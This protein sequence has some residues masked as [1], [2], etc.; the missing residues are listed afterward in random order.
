MKQSSHGAGVG[1]TSDPVGRP[2]SVAFVHGCRRELEPVGFAEPWVPTDLSREI[3]PRRLQRQ[4]HDDTVV[5]HGD[6]L[7]HGPP[8]LPRQ[9]DRGGTG[10]RRRQH[11]G[12]PRSIE[13]QPVD[14]V[15]L[16]GAVAVAVVDRELVLDATEGESAI[17]D[18][19]GPRRHRVRTPQHRI[20]RF[21]SWGIDQERLVADLDLADA[22]ASRRVDV[23][24]TSSARRVR[25]GSSWVTERYCTDASARATCDPRRGDESRVSRRRLGGRRFDRTRAVRARRGHAHRH[26]GAGGQTGRQ[27]LGPAD[28]RRRRRA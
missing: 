6:H 12:G 27:A 7:A 18:P 16:L 26:R 14:G 11:R 9:R 17:A 5:E 10:R 23:T 4:A 1:S 20:G 22:A 8:E 15:G 28:L 3:G 19:A 25:I 21:G 13:D 24:T 2:N